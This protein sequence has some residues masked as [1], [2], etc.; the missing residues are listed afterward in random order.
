[1][2]L[3]L[4]ETFVYTAF[5]IYNDKMINNKIVAC[6]FLT[7]IIV[8]LSCDAH[9]RQKYQRDI[10]RRNYGQ[11]ASSTLLET[12]VSKR[13]CLLQNVKCKTTADCCEAGDGCVVCQRRFLGTFGPYICDLRRFRDGGKGSIIC[14]KRHH[15][16]VYN[17]PPRCGGDGHRCGRK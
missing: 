17:D 3:I 13:N 11:N 9:A 12:V 7:L 4:T 8:M 5:T 6:I 1:M 2:Y 14:P 16:G 15:Y 10:S